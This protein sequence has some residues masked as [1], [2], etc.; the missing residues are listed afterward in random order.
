MKNKL[1]H[2]NKRGLQA[3]F[4]WL[5]KLENVLIRKFK[6]FRGKQVISLALVN[7]AEI[8]RLNKVYRQ[9][10]KVTD[11]LSFNIDSPE[12]LGE[13]II[14]LDKAKEQSKIKKQIIK[15]ELQLLTVHGILHL[16]NYDHE[17]GPKY[18]RQQKHLEEEVLNLLS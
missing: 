14:C 4:S 8:R 7:K 5:T 1:L 18:A 9:Q 16:L 2:L 13:I 10:N 6:I 12:V 17:L 3:D 11:V 15:K